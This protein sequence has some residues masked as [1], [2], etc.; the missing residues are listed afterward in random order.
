MTNP[1]RMSFRFWEAMIRSGVSAYHARQRFAATDEPP[2]APGWCANRFGQ[3]LTL[4]PDGRAIQIGGEHEDYYDPDFCIYNDVFVFEADG[5]ITIYGYPKDVFPPTDF[6]T[7]NLLDDSIY[8]IGSLG[9][10]GQ[11]RPGE[12]PV[13]RLNLGSFRI[14]RLDTQGD[15]P[16]WIY[17]HRSAAQ[18]ANEI[19]VWSGTVV[20]MSDRGETHD[21]NPGVFVLNLK[22]LRWRRESQT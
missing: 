13:F 11:R 19:R 14:D 22:T 12:T 5:T 16:G 9:Y 4:L 20:S 15:N 10:A 6:H 1:E 17:N 3:S 2:H 8:I 21:E 18:D 7:A